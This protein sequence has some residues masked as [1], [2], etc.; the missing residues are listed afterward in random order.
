MLANGQH[1]VFQLLAREDEAQLAR[2][3]L[4]GHIAEQRHGVAVVHA[5]CVA[6]GVQV[7]ADALRGPLLQQSVDH[8]KQEARAVFDAAAVLVGALVAAI[9]QELVKQVA[10]GCMHFDKVKTCGFGIACGLHK[11]LHDAGNFCSLQRT[12]H[13]IG[14]L[15][16]QHAD[17]AF[18]GN[19][20][21]CY[22][23]L[24]IEQFRV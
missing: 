21:G 6:H 9:V 13:D 18:G 15:G 23:Q 22:G 4:L 3:D 8:L 16:A 20:T 5:V 12:W 1:A 2:F 14:A 17:L 11:V 10:V 7:H 24:A 19:R